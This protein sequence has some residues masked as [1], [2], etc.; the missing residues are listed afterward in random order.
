MSEMS[1]S[2][3]GFKLE[4]AALPYLALRWYSIV[5]VYSVVLII[6]FVLR[7]QGGNEPILLQLGPIHFRWY[8]L[9][10]ACG[11]VLT[12]LLTAY[13]AELNGED[14]N[15]V[16]RLLPIVLLS[17]LTMARSWF[18]VFTWETYSKHPEKIIAIWEGGIAIQGGVIGG[19]LGGIFYAR[20]AK[21]S[22]WR[23]ADYVAP[24]L[25]LAQAIGRWGNFMN[26]EAYGGNTTLP[27]GIEIPCQFRTDGHPG[28]ID[29]RCSTLGGPGAPP[30][31]LFHPAF[32]YESLWN[33]ACFLILLYFSLH[34][35]I[36][37]IEQKMG[38][39][40]RS[41]EYFSPTWLEQ[42]LGWHR[43]SGDIFLLYWVIY[44][45]GRFFT[46]AIRTDSLTYGGLKTA[47]VTAVVAIIV[48]GSWLIWRHRHDNRSTEIT[49]QIDTEH[50]QKQEE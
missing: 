13:L 44:S 50:S 21:I 24:G 48:C 19:L 22:V 12:T 9:L 3:K 38:W 18:V 20:R 43:K 10:I 30:D 26:N 33:Y 4:W 7:A 35:G 2:Q 47:Q 46:E 15:H 6:F 41:K 16:W 36:S 28:T 11:A 49:E 25:V 8:G 17:S 31:A 29:T 39:K 34:I 14:Y 42:K 37:F 1:K 27:W 23:W 32:L 45:F 5:A 40:P